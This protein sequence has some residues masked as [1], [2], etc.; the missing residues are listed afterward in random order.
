M[1]QLLFLVGG[2]PYYVGQVLSFKAHAEDVLILEMQLFLNIV[3]DGRR[4]R[5]RKGKDGN[6][7]LDLPDIRNLQVRRTEIIA[8]LTDAVGFIYR[9][10]ADAHVP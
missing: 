1:K 5:G 6:T 3:D 2:I 7:G 9:D 10:E 8:P 4:G